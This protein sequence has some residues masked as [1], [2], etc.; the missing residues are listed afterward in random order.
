M[1]LDPGEVRRPLRFLNFGDLLH[2]ELISGWLPEGGAPLMLDVTF[3]DDHAVWQQGVPGLYVLYASIVDPA[4]ALLGKTVETRSFETIVRAATR[5]LPERLP[6]LMRP[7]T[8]A[9]HA[10]VQADVR[11]LRAQLPATMK[12]EA[13]RRLGEQWITA[14]AEETRALLNP[15]AHSRRAVPRSAELRATE[16]LVAAAMDEFNRLRDAD[17]TAARSAWSHRLPEF[18][19]SL[20]ARLFVVREEGRDAVLLA[21]EELQRAEDTLSVATERGNPAQITRAENARDAATDTLHMTEVFWQQR[22]LWLQECQQG[23]GSVQPREHL[24]ALLRTRRVR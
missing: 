3:F 5:T 10:A 15:M 13:R 12:L 6:D 24:A 9:V 11:W 7:F 1:S 18:E 23:V 8:E 17:S 2:D 19:R 16:D 14:G 21:H 20:R 22:D 4:D